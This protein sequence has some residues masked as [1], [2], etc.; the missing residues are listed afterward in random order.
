M[1]KY[2]GVGREVRSL[3]SKLT[4][5][6]EPVSIDEAF[7]D[8]SGTARLHGMSAAKALARFASEVEAELRITVSIGLS[9][10]KFLA[11]IASDLDK[12]RGFAVLGGEE[13]ARFLATKPVA[14]IL[15][16]GKVAQQRLARDGLRTIGDLQRC[17]EAE[18]LRRY[19][20]E[21]RRLARLA[22][23]FDDRPVIAERE[24]K[25]ISAET[26][27]DQDIAQL[28]PLE[29]RLWRLSEKVSARL[30]EHALAGSTVTLK[31]KGAD[32]RIR[33]RA[34][35]LGHPTQLAARIFAVGRDLLAREADGTM[36]R[37]I[38]IGVSSLSPADEA[39]LGDLLDRRTAEAE[40]AI[41]RLRQRFGEAAVVK[42]LAIAEP[43]DEEPH[44]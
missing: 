17:G 9:C 31:L 12:P 18:L 4:P 32:F 34:Q 33:T 26:T 20:E 35:S 7:M 6:V 1:Q 21:G 36:F 16:V 38:G 28:R 8:L 24:A 43:D 11:K 14:L 2:A 30:K 37:L 23:G 19:G 41:D 25:S 42:G 27:F 40:R 39:G 29:L 10:N 5:L 13:A 15:G 3:M 44:A 22:H